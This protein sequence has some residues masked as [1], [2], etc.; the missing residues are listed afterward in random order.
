MGA[1]LSVACGVA[2][3]GCSLSK[4]I[5]NVSFYPPLPPYYTLEERNGKLTGI[6]DCEDYCF[7]LG[8]KADVF[9]MKLNVAKNIDI[10][11]FHFKQPNPFGAI[12]YSHANACDC[13]STALR[14][15]ELGRT[16]NL[17]IYLYDYEGYGWSSGECS[18]QHIYRD[19][20]V[21]YQYVHSIWKSNIYL[22]GE[23]IGSSPTCFLASTTTEGLQGVI[24]HSA[25]LSGARLFSSSPFLRPC[26]PFNNYNRIISI[27][28][29]IFQMHA[30]DDEVVPIRQA[31]ELNERIHNKFEPWWVGGCSHN[32]IPVFQ[33]ERYIERLRVFIDTTIDKSIPTSLSPSISPSSSSDIN[34]NQNSI[35]ICVPTDIIPNIII[36]HLIPSENDLNN[37]NNN[38]TVKINDNDSIKNINNNDKNTNNN[39]TISNEQTR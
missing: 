10:V 36:P 7:E 16:L 11:V 14:C 39:N 5:S 12:I 13:G 8:E 29:P 27:N 35:S 19:I 4:F 37:D 24:L 31:I 9:P 2:N 33:G 26:D 1:V 25:I 23:S 20:Q 34:D 30:I 6:V 32:T 15:A 28:L 18:E 38:N 22:Y 3:S 17:D 21:V